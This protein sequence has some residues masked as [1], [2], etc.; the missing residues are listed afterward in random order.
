MGICVNVP[1][2]S[3]SIKRKLMVKVV[4]LKTDIL[5]AVIFCHY[6]MLHKGYEYKKDGYNLKTITVQSSYTERYSR[7]I[8]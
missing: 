8:F 5:L 1:E 6:G 3:P 4:L 7:S 2:L